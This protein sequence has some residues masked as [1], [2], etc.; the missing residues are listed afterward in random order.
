[1][2]PTVIILIVVV[3]VLLVLA[4]AAAGFLVSRRRNSERLQEHYGPEYERSVS[5]TGNRRDA[6]AQLTEREKRHDKLDVRD[7]R[8]EERDRFQASWDAIQRGFVDDPVQSVRD[9][10]RLVADIMRTRG[11]PVGDPADDKDRRAEDVSVEH[12]EVV[13]HYREAQAVRA[14]VEHG[15]ADTEQ[16]R[17]AVASYRELVDALLL[18]HGPA[19]SHSNGRH[20]ADTAATEEQSR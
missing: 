20:P 16:Q 3:I 8:P 15:T 6:E 17:H 1:M 13:Q 11:Y 5:E 4:L 18:G 9:A 2:E 7:L 14:A 19:N 10:D 12:P